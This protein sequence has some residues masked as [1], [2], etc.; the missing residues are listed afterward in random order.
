M[1]RI[2]L[3]MALVS[4]TAAKAISQSAYYY[5]NGNKIYIAE[6]ARKVC[7]VKDKK[8]NKMGA[9][10]QPAKESSRFKVSQTIKDNIYDITVYEAGRGNEGLPSLLKTME[11]A[12]EADNAMVLPCYKNEYGDELVLTNY[13]NV[14]LK[15]ESD[16][17]LLREKAVEYNLEKPH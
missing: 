5:F 8:G 1:K 14:E 13:L 7:V 10:F 3:F 11:E 9:S 6:N 2:L 17:P 15:K 12:A 4:I 16:Y